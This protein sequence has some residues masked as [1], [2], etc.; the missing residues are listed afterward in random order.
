M[1]GL[2]SG[3]RDRLEMTGPARTVHYPHGE[4]FARERGSI[5]LSVLWRRMLTVAPE[6]ARERIDAHLPHS[7]DDRCAP[8]EFIL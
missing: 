1:L 6:L 2:L 8:L 3:I 5:G 4:M 7:I